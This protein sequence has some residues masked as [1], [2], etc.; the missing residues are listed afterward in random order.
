[1]TSVMGN[2]LFILLLIFTITNSIYSYRLT[3]EED[4][5]HQLINNDEFNRRSVLWPKICFP[6][7]RKKDAQQNMNDQNQQYGYSKHLAVRMA[8]KCYPFDK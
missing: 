5:E 8:R 6:S 2:T 4:A 3:E 7:L 1:M